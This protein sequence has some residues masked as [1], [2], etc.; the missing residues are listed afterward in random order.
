MLQSNIQ[1]CA[2][3]RS[4]IC[5]LQRRE[6]TFRFEAVPRSFIYASIHGFIHYE[7]KG[8]LGYETVQSGKCLSKFQRHVN[9]CLSTV[10]G[11]KSRSRRLVTVRKCNLIIVISTRTPDQSDLKGILPSSSR[12]SYSSTIIQY[13]TVWVLVVSYRRFVEIYNLH[14]LGFNNFLPS[15]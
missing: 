5:Q 10:R 8:P 7:K 2:T 15:V 9:K 1:H 6:L 14:L 12:S 3:S 13:A 11:V 4:K